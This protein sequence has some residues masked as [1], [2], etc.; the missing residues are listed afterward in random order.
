[1][2]KSD[3]F[4]TSSNPT[5]ETNKNN[6]EKYDYQNS[7]VLKSKNN[8]TSHK[9]VGEKYLFS[10]NKYEKIG[11]YPSGVSHSAWSPKKKAKS[12]MNYNSND[13]DIINPF[14]K[15]KSYTRKQIDLEALGLDPIHRQKCITEFIDLTRN[16]VPN[17]NKDFV[18]AIHKDERI[19]AKNQNM[20]ANFLDLHGEYKNLCDLP[21]C[22][23]AF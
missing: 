2:N 9:K 6:F 12:Y 11:F 23:K 3:I 22:K 1:M 13:Y 10:E 21:F 20:C 8:D 15:K 18:D 14:I 16:F 5:N 19:F 17:S 4:F 7:D